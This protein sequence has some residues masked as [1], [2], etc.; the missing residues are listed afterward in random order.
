[1][2]LTRINELAHNRF[3]RDGTVHEDHVLM[4]NSPLNKS[5]GVVLWFVESYNF[6]NVEMLKNVNI[7]AATVTVRSLL[8]SLLINR[9]HECDKLARDDPVKVSVLHPLVVFVLFNIKLVIAIPALFYSELKAFQA[10]LNC[11][12][13]VALTFAGISVG[14]QQAVIGSECLPSLD[15]RLAEHHNHVGTHKECAVCKFDVVVAGLGVVV[16]FDL[17][18]ELVFFE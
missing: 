9:T 5:V 18:F 10:V 17:A 2:F 8:A 6:G 3:W 16:N 13:V 7:A 15:C 14:T 4:F 12:F 1:M 11:A